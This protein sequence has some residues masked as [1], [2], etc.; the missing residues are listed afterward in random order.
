MPAITKL[1][2]PTDITH[3]SA[4]RL[5]ITRYECDML[6]QGFG[7]SVGVALAERLLAAEFAAL[8]SRPR[9]T[10][11]GIG[12]SGRAVHLSACRGSAPRHPERP[13]FLISASRLKRLQ[14]QPARSYR[15]TRSF[16]RANHGGTGGD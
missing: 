11:A 4:V 15:L 16:G 6:G 8:G 9:C 3:G 13:S 12:G 7:N 1:S 5:A 10:L 2:I 14:R